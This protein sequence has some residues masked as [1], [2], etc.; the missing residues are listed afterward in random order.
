VRFTRNTAALAV[1]AWALPAHAAEPLHVQ[2]LVAEALANNPEVL[3]AQKRY[4]AA[5]QR[6]SRESSLPDPILSLGYA[7][8]GTPLPGGQL[9]SNPTSNIG[10][11]VSQEIPYA[12]K[13]RLRG[14]IAA[15]EAEAEFWQYQATQLS[16]RSRVTQAFHRLHHAYASLEILNEGKEVLTQMIRISEA[17]YTAGRTSQQDIFK[18]QIQLSMMETRIIRMRQ[19]QHTTEAEINSLLNR[20]PG[21][22]L[23]EPADS[24]AE[25]LPRTVDELLAKAATTSPELTG[26]LKDIARDELSVNLARKDFHSDYTVS[27]GYFN[28]GSMSPMYQV[29]VDIPLRLHT[30]KKQRPA[31]NEQVDLLAG[32]R[33]SFEAAE[34]TLQFRVREAYLTAETAWRLMKLYEDTIL[35]QSQLTVDS[36]LAAYQTGAADFVAVL[37][38]LT[39]KV[40]VEEQLHEQEMNYLV[41]R[42]KLEE[43]TGVEL[44]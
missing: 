20:R 4:E 6:P 24:E 7:S 8:N 22:P 33:R 26:K 32:A 28:Q 11:M 12:G 31:L 9:G 21:S 5:R 30:D 13:R 15:K 16:V 35:P 38:N 40:D 39:T 29:R 23:A 34:Q 19:D 14:D 37:N 17:R 27:A 3:A 44:K 36:S 2:D 43:M 25:P 18:A 10:F 1:L 42:A 41:A